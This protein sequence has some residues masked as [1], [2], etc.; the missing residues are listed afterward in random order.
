MISGFSGEGVGERGVS[1]PLAPPGSPL[2]VTTWVLVASS[3]EV[4]SSA[5]FPLCPDSLACLG[6]EGDRQDLQTH[7]L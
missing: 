4:V 2:V 7:F 5:H 1:Y 6:N 3:R